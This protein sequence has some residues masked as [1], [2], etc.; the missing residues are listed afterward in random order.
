LTKVA[1]V[2]AP[3]NYPFWEDQPKWEANVATREIA[4]TNAAFASASALQS[5][6]QFKP[7]IAG[8]ATQKAMIAIIL[9]LIAIAAYLWLRF[10]S[11]EFGLAGIIALFHDVAITLSLIYA[12]HYIHDTAIG[13]LLRLQDF[14]VD[15]ALIAAFLTIVGYS[16][17]DTIVIFD[18][19]RENR[20]RLS[21][22]S[23]TLVNKSIN[24]T[25]SRTIIT[26][27]T[28]FMAVFVM[29]IA[30]GDGI[31]GFAF[32]LLVGVLTG[33]YSTI[34][35][36][37][38]MLL[39]PRAMWTVSILIAAVAAAGVAAT[40]PVSWLRNVFYVVIV[41]LTIFGLFRQWARAQ[42]AAA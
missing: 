31:H 24:E 18:R 23:P 6:T 22:V 12:C 38:P 39:H 34:A 2:V 8:E 16:I 11:V 30:G 28:T 25:L 37:T 7:Q 5:A 40:V 41:V 20:G 4:V 32:A 29:Y 15:L 9:S 17:N 35:I 10:G 1:I 36:A 42:A 3:G 21:T 14:R 19:V 27:L 13:Q 26:S 33:T